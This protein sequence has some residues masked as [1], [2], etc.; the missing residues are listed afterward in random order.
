VATIITEDLDPIQ[1]GVHRA[2]RPLNKGK[3]SHT[4]SGEIKLPKSLEEH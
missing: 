3:L 4:P 1:E 2:L